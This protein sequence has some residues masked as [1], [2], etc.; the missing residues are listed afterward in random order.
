MRWINYVSFN[1]RLSY[2]LGQD[3]R[4]L[5]KRRKVDNECRSFNNEWTEKY[6]SLL[7]FGKPTSLICN[8]SVAVN[9]EF[10][11]KCHYV[12][13]HSRFSDYRGQMRKD[14]LTVLNSALK[15]S[16]VYFKSKT[17]NHK[18]TFRHDMRSLN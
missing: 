15:S 3:F 4:M 14:K 9:K 13:K 5:A 18:K 11:I 16:V 12:T 6:F 17:L 8:Q 10:N 7:H 1:V 2:N